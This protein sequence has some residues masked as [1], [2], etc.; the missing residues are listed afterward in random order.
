MGSTGISLKRKRKTPDRLQSTASI[1]SKVETDLALGVGT[2]RVKRIDPINFL[3]ENFR[4]TFDLSGQNNASQLAGINNFIDNRGEIDRNGREKGESGKTVQSSITEQQ[5]GELAQR[6]GREFPY[7]ESTAEE[8]AK[9]DFSKRFS[10][11]AFRNGNLASAVLRNGGK[12]MFVSCLK[13]ALKQPEPTDFRQSK[14]FSITSVNDPLRNSIDKA[15]IS[16]YTDRAIELVVESIFRARQTLQLFERQ[17]SDGSDK[18]VLGM[19]N[20]IIRN[21]YPFLTISKDAEKLVVYEEKLS[22]LVLLEG[23]T[24]DGKE[25]NEIARQKA[26]LA[27]G[28]TKTQGLITRKRQMQNQFFYRMEQLLESS[29]KAEAAFK[30]PHFAD[31]VVGELMDSFE[32]T[33]D[34]RDEQ[35]DQDARDD[36]NDQ[37]EDKPEES[38]EKAE[39]YSRQAEEVFTA[40]HVA[41]SVALGTLG[42]PKDKKTKKAK[43]KKPSGKEKR[44]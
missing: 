6:L 37:N 5:Q 15:E 21:A 25:R 14:L 18:A 32:L 16:R 19:K 2:T 26:V 36:Q 27:V 28:I 34:D 7:Y 30:A 11:I 20:N 33:E 9:G 40:P 41:S 12:T 3:K 42:L 38:S 13:R 17:A 24:G 1:K 4:S 39:K 22:E 31:S 43:P 23:N 8:K 29:G 35:D 44:I 10:K